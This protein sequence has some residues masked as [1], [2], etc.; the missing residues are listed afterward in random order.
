MAR[1]RSIKPGFCTSES[2]A[3]LSIPCRLHF[4]MLWTYADDAGRGLDNT[5]LLKAALWPLD[6]DVDA[7]QIEDWQH[8]L[9]QHGRICRYENAG[10]RYFE[11][12]NFAEHQKPNRPQDSDIPAPAVNDH[13]TI[14][15]RAVSDLWIIPD[16]D[17][18][19]PLTSPNGLHGASS[20]RSMNA[21][22]AHTAVVGDV[23]VEGEGEEQ[24]QERV[25]ALRTPSERSA[26]LDAA[27]EL[28]LQ[29][30]GSI[31]RA[32]T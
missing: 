11:V 12:T 5:R 2:I 14:S 27:V 22:G 19:P 31:E 29:R 26:L 28:L 25:P 9:E 1:I 10:R 13:C 7:A 3:A 30:D 15:E 8:E 20:E 17:D 4:A 16:P 6:D 18:S 21:H 32:T 23:E 24:E